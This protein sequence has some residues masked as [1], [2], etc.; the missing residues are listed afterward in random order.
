MWNIENIF[1]RC[2]ESFDNWSSI[3]WSFF[4]VR[5]IQLL[6]TYNGESTRWLKRSGEE[7]ENQSEKKFIPYKPMNR[8]RAEITACSHG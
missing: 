4:L 3:D 8:L 5:F 6:N 1:L 7:L 2:V